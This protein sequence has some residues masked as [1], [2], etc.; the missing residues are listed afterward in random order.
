MI[1]DIGLVPS[2][3]FVWDEHVVH[4]LSGIRSSSGA[5]NVVVTIGLDSRVV[6]PMNEGGHEHCH[7]HSKNTTGSRTT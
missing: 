4:S 5:E 6:N 7:C 1:Y 2:V 3:A